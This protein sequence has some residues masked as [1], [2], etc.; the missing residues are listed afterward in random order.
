MFPFQQ[1]I[2]EFVKQ[3]RFVIRERFFL[4]I[5]HHQHDQH[6]RVVSQFQKAVW[7][8]NS[9]QPNYIVFGAKYPT[10]KP[11]KVCG[12][13]PELVFTGIESLPGALPS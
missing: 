11:L 7:I 10:T 5:N 1:G 6:E 13:C 4:V 2:D 3:L 12:V 9:A 8:G